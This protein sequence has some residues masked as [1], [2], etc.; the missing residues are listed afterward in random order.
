MRLVT[1]SQ[2]G[3]NDQ[4]N[5]FPAFQKQS[6]WQV[7]FNIMR[8]DM[9]SIL[10]LAFVLLMMAL[11]II[12]ANAAT[13]AALIATINCPPPVT[14]SCDQS[15]EPSVTGS[16]TGT[17]NC[18]TSPDLSITWADDI[19]GLTNCSN[20]GTLLR[21]WTAAD[22]CN[23]SATC[24]QV[25]T[26]EDVTSPTIMCP[27]TMQIS[28]EQDTT[29]ASL[30]LPIVSDNCASPNEIVV[31]H[32]DQNANLTGCNGTGT[33]TRMWFGTDPCGNNA[34]CTQTIIISDQN[35]PE[36]IC[37]DNIQ[38]EC[39]SNI[40]PITVGSATASDGCTPPEDLLINHSDNLLGLTGCQGT[41]SVVRTWQV[42]DACGKTDVCT[43]I[44][45][46]VDE[47]SPSITCPENT[48]ISCE[49]DQSPTAQGSATG[50]DN[51]G[52][53]IISYTNDLSLLNG[54]NNSGILSRIWTATDGC[55]NNNSCAQ[56]INIS[57]NTNPTITCPQN[58][59]IDCSQSTEPNVTGQL[60]SSDNCS[61]GN[62]LEVS[63]IDLPG[64]LSGCNGTGVIQRTWTATDDCDNVS[65][66]LQVI[67]I[68]DD[69]NPDVTCPP[70]LVISC[71]SSIDP[72]NTGTVIANDNCTLSEELITSF[73]D[74]VENS[75][76]CNGTGMIVRTWSVKD[77]CGNISTCEQALMIIDDKQPTLSCAPEVTISCEE[78]SSPDATGFATAVD[79]CTS[80]DEIVIIY[81]DIEN[82]NG[83][84]E[85][86]TLL[87]TW[88]AKDACLNSI[89]CTQIIHIID[90][91]SPE[92]T[93]PPNVD[94]SC[95]DPLSPDFTGYPEGTD[96]CTASQDLIMNYANDQS[97]LI[98]C[99]AT[100]VL[101]RNWTVID[102][103]N[104]VSTC[105]QTI[106]ISDS[107]APVINCPENLEVSCEDDLSTNALGF[108]T[109]DDNCTPTQLIQVN[110]SDNITVLPAC[111]N[112]GILV[113]TFTASDAC[114]NVSSC[115][116]T[117][118]VVDET[119]PTL[120]CPASLTFNCSDDVSPAAIGFAL[121]SDNCSNAEFIVVDYVD[122][123][124]GLAGC[125][126]TGNMFRTW[127]AIDLCSNQ[128]TCVQTLTIV[129]VIKPALTCPDA[130]T[131]SCE[132]P[133]DTSVAGN[134]SVLDNCTPFE[135]LNIS[136]IDTEQGLVGCNGSGNVIRTWTVKDACGNSSNCSQQI[137]VAD[138]TPPVIACTEPITISCGTSQDTSSVKPPEVTDNCSDASEISILFFDNATQ[139]TGCNG[140][141][142]LTRNWI[143]FD[144]CGNQS[145]CIQ[146]I[147][148]VDNK[149]P[150]ITVPADKQ[151]NCELADDMGVLGFAT[152]IDNCSPANDV[153]VFYED[154]DHGLTGCNGTGLKVR[155]WIAAD[156]CGN[157][158]TAYQNITL[159]DTLAP[160]FYC[161]LDID[162]S[163][164]ANIYDMDEMGEVQVLVDNCAPISD[165]IIDYAD[166]IINLENCEDAPTIRRMWSVSDQCGNV[167]TCIQRI[168]IPQYTSPLVSFPSD[169]EINCEDDIFNM[170]LTGLPETGNGISSLL[171]DTVYYIDMQFADKDNDFLHMREWYAIDYCGNI[172]IDT[173]YITEY[174]DKAPNI[175]LM[176]MQISFMVELEHIISIEDILVEALDNCDPEISYSIIPEVLSCEDFL[177]SN[178]QIITVTATDEHGNATIVQA[179]A[180]VVD[181]QIVI[182]CPASIIV[183]LGPGE[184]NTVVN[185]TVAATVPCGADPEL[186]QT[187]NSELETGDFFPIGITQLSFEAKDA[188]G[189]IETCAFTI[190]VNGFVGND[191]LIC[192][193]TI[194]VSVNASCISQIAADEI[195]E[196]DNYGCYDNFVLSSPNPTVQFINGELNSQ[197]YIG[198]YLEICVTDTSTGNF[199]CG[200]AF[201]EDKLAPFITCPADDTV[202]CSMDFS[203]LSLNLF[204]VPEGSIV[205][206]LPGGG[207]SAT[208]IDNCNVVTLT[209]Q[210]SEEVNMCEGDYIR[211]ITRLWTAT[212][213]FGNTDTC[214]HQIFLRRGV[215]E[216][217]TFPA[218]T[219]LEC[220]SACLLPDGSPDPICTGTIEGDFCDQFFITM[221]DKRINGC[222]KT[223][224]IVRTWTLVDWCN[225]DNFIE[226]DQVINIDDTTPPVVSC[227]EVIQVSLDPGV[228]T[229]TVML[230]PPP[231]TDGCMSDSI[232]FELT[233]GIETYPQ[234]NG[235]FIIEDL[236]IGTHEFTWNVR[237]VCNNATTCTFSVAI[238]DD[239]VPIAYCD[240]H[241]IVAIQNEDDMGVS[242]SPATV[243]DDGSFDACSDVTF[244]ARRMLSCIDFDWNNSSQTHIPDGNVN[245]FDTG[246]GFQKT[247]PFSCCDVNAEDPIMIQLEV[248]DEAGNVNFCMVEVEVQDKIAPT[249]VCAPDIYISCNFWYDENILDDLSNK[250]F[251]TVL[252]GFFFNESERKPIII[253]DP[254]NT[255]IS[256]PHNW[257][258]DGFAT[259]NCNL[260]LSLTVK[261][262]DDCSGETL[263]GNAPQGAIRLI[264][265]KF[266]AVDP[267]GK[268]SVCTQRIWVINY[269]PFYINA[270]NPLDP[271]D[272]IVWPTDI[273]V[274]HCGI[275]DTIY[276][277]ILNDQ[278]GT[279]AINLKETKLQFSEGSCM[280]ILREWS[281]IDWCQYNSVT[282]AGLWKYTQV[283]K[284]TD[285]AAAVFTDCPDGPITICSIDDSVT[286]ILGT[287][288]EPNPCA[289][290]VKLAHLIEDVCSEQVTYD[291]KLYPFNT[292]APLQVVNPTQVSLV[293]GMAS[294][295]FNSETCAI[296]NIRQNGLPYNSITDQNDTHRILFSVVDACGNI[297]TCEYLFRLEDCK[298]PSPVCINGLSTVIMPSNGEITIWANEFD[299][300]SFDNCTAEL[301][302]SF[303]GDNY[304]PSHT[305]TC[306]N[307]PGVG[308]QIPVQIWVW[309]ASGNRD[310]CTTN[311]V[312]TD[313]DDVCG[314]GQ[315]G[316][317][318]EVATD[319]QEMIENATV[320]LSNPNSFFTQM[321]TVED[322]QYNFANVPVAS[323][324]E[325][326]IERNDAHKNGVSSLDIVKLQKHLIGLVPFTTP[327]QY[328]AADVNNSQ[329][330][331]AIDIVELRKLILGIYTEFPDNKSW[332]FVAN[333][334]EF[335]NPFNPWP[336]DEQLIL[337]VDSS[338]VIQENFTGIKI[339]DLNQTAQANLN[340]IVTRS[341]G[342]AKVLEI[343][344]IVKVGT[345]LYEVN[346]YSKDYIDINGIQFTLELEEGEFVD[347]TSGHL[348]INSSNY[349][350]FD[351]RLT[352]SWSQ[353]NPTFVS[354]DEPLFTFIVDKNMEGQNYAQSLTK[355]LQLTSA[356][357]NAEMYDE[358]NEVFGIE[359]QVRGEIKKEIE[360]SEIALYQN[361][362]NPF[363]GETTISFDLPEE[364][365][366]ILTIFNANGQRILSSKDIFPA[367]KGQWVVKGD[368]LEGAGMYYYTVQ[369][370]MGHAFTKKM[371]KVK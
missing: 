183:D 155:M 37:P 36:I 10:Q 138:Q 318:G 96:N 15:T 5:A 285:S 270:Q 354:P 269:D 25:I 53:A 182:E 330:V 72:D 290:H 35:N 186:T 131:L 29:P 6:K 59:T 265:R 87:R 209:F 247:V 192:N 260:D 295:S 210:D 299:A 292:G 314:F 88:N 306:E 140:S 197:A 55:G 347:I 81:S 78:S 16:A 279:I 259:D 27:S 286:D 359:L 97:G 39:D 362:P 130:I 38:I 62:L 339:G 267:N 152:A 33:F 48:N 371:I 23:E 263:P 94:L 65:S 67:T 324:Y 1:T 363:D 301:L 86:G 11:S 240:L 214:S 312:V 225:P 8:L 71:D 215:F 331:S 291:V 144:G 60:V 4:T 201:I 203:P 326:K 185:Y 231:T 162:V 63:F 249:I 268:S 289:A 135:D 364:M 124:S 18:G 244:R 219:V 194:N 325:L 66:C 104:N 198:Q 345:D 40:D 294:I 61:S 44:I 307:I 113:R 202:S 100:G 353:A 133:T 303:S 47:T 308:V 293:N 217:F 206:P 227:P 153:N 335:S 74:N 178:S 334:Y 245:S 122:N 316:I 9:Q 253:N 323:N 119:A 257:G 208:G 179:E 275:P 204:P 165:V 229:S 177:T 333:N 115:T 370:D 188:L 228:C 161:P 189:V 337:N 137:T 54:C 234:V 176:D 43:Q 252:D 121:A 111:N 212:D 211:T 2:P 300:S 315:S 232:Y 167:G 311:I 24:Q 220:N 278:C 242:L 332:R 112:T 118:Q 256:Q 181:P 110:Y 283:V 250:T 254:G 187:D 149:A 108:A 132:S 58:I 261:V 348:D 352:F 158:D 338:L 226:V 175:T 230:T 116:Q 258:F 342:F 57:D 368:D 143:A 321:T 125:N 99:M 30:G 12:Q 84:N 79:N 95:T 129:D 351:N 136:F 233:N 157:I 357:T 343:G 222:G 280:K 327:Y 239:V 319:N 276:P 28:C 305:Y 191:F 171:V 92:I 288:D 49:N 139:L 163:T 322:G 150:V 273:E 328:I 46:I 3:N 141:G 251:G 205:T 196:G 346:V 190:T 174:D 235:T 164:D 32:L 117:I 19:S 89:S 297:S 272:D 221:E 277:T 344:E 224:A 26:I 77:E 193:D 114:G 296:F 218:D 248:T 223:Y 329:T 83:C 199:C 103:C 13:N 195:L 109:A 42:N 128:S 358:E 282:G 142:I 216:D 148:V 101:I 341:G 69:I 298:Q 52:I 349:A 366:V 309:D 365:E 127:T 255:T 75:N 147:Q 156:G 172:K 93:C 169:M 146:I 238:V 340:Q 287:I 106:T 367:G 159:I 50:E 304:E 126:G 102:A 168:S 85:T 336:F 355:N 70:D 134:I 64:V 320:T 369:T 166:D 45:T 91:T 356:I 107:D 21:T 34:E 7:P 207:F 123:V 302:F 184:C 73:L 284:I 80:S 105:A 180:L 350:L 145:S 170:E 173:Q 271:T 90:E 14:S 281:V 56:I 237:D 51:C 317:I 236:P 31:S 266:I 361:S 243:F 310:F 151:I 200:I 241:T 262:F 20:T 213:A 160:L 120:Q 68:T 274:D 360:T 264:E 98:N 17:T 76:G 22:N 313:N 82:Y 41:G 246:L 154:V